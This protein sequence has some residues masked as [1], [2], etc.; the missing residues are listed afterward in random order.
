MGN[1]QKLRL[2]LL[3]VGLVMGVV[4]WTWPTTSTQLQDK[5][6]YEKQQREDEEGGLSKYDRMDLAI[7]QEVEMTKDPA[8]GFVPR[9]R[10]AIA[11][12]QIERSQFSR[13]SIAGTEWKERGSNNVGG[14]T[15]AV[16]FDPNDG[17][18]RRVFAGS[19]SGGLWQC[20]DITAYDPQWEPID[21]LFAN[22][23]VTTIAYDPTNTNTLYFGTGEGFFNG[24]A[25]R[26]DGIWKS[27]DGGSTW[28]QLS[29]TTGN[30]FDYVQKIVVADNGDV[31]AA[32]RSRFCNVGGIYKSTNGG[33]SWSNV[34]IGNGAPCGGSAQYEW[35]SDIEI[36]DNGDLYA[37]MGLGYT[38]GIYKSTD[39]GA[40]WTQLTGGGLP[41]SDYERI[42]LACAPSDSNT[43]LAVMQ[44]ATPSGSND[45][46]GIYLSTDG[47]STWSTL[48]MAIDHASGNEF[49]RG[50]SWYD[51]IAAFDPNDANRI[52]LG[53]VDI[54][55][56]EDQGSTWNTVG[57]WYGDMH[58][59]VHADQHA[60]YFLP[61]SS[62]LLL[63]GNDGG[64]YYSDDAGSSNPTLTPKNR[65]YNTLQ[66][67]A[68]DISPTANEPKLLGGAQDNGSHRIE[69]RGVTY[70][71]EVT[72]GDGAFCHIDQNDAQ[73]WITSY[74]Y[75]QYR[76]SSDSGKDF[77]TVNYSGSIGRFINP[78]DYDDDANIL[79]CAGANSRYVRWNDPHSGSSFDNVSASWSG[80]VS[81]ITVD[82]QN[83]HTVWFGTGSGEVYEVYDAHSGSPTFV[84]R[85]GG[86]SGTPYV[87]GIAIDPSDTNHLLVTFSNYGVSSIYETTDGGSNWTNVDVNGF[88]DMPVRD[89]LISPNSSSEA[90]IATELGV[91]STNNLNGASTVWGA[92]NTGLANVRVDQLNRRSSDN[93]VVAA[94]H[95]R[96]F[97][98]S[99][100]F[101]TTAAAE[102]GS[103]H[104]V[105]YIGQS[106]QFYDDSRSASSYSWNFG[107]GNSSTLQ[108]PAHN[109]N[110][111]GQYTVSLTINGSV[112]ETKTNYI[113]VLPDR[114]IPYEL[115]DGGNFEVNPL[116]FAPE[117]WE[118]TPFERGSSTVSDKNGTNSGSNAWVTGL[119]ESFYQSDSW[120]ELYTPNFD[121][122][123][124]GT[125]TLDF[126][127][128][129][130]VFSNSTFTSD[131]FILQYSTDLGE[132]WTQIGDY[133]GFY[134]FDNTNSSTAF[135]NTI[136][137]MIGNTAGYTLFSLD[138]SS[139][140]GNP[141]VAFRFV[142]RSDYGNEDEGLAI[143]DFTITSTPFLLSIQ[144]M[145]LT[146]RGEGM[147]ALLNWSIET[148]TPVTRLELERSTDGTTF[149]FTAD[150]GPTL[151]GQYIDRDLPGGQYYYRLKAWDENGEISYSNIESVAIGQFNLQLYPNPV[152]AVLHIS[153]PIN[154]TYTI[155]GMSGK[156]Y[157]AGKLLAGQQSILVN[158]L[159]P[160]Q[161]LLRF[162]PPSGETITARFVKY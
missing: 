99:D 107:D 42:E 51:L 150:V 25:V 79:Y 20:Q 77:S 93:L 125:Y 39:D 128:N 111:A 113:T 98:T 24:D 121:F 31:Y 58:Q 45:C 91:W 152:Q 6:V 47:G 80:Q 159:P 123:V 88:P 120:A 133:P 15:R 4:W 2:T 7:A 145:D 50:Q 86:W 141:D 148:T 116:D 105:A 94:T 162:T 89:V 115:T 122:S 59:E 30:G 109:Y 102:F 130:D 57:Q 153:V 19:V 40:T 108:N 61:G 144:S 13:S 36:A 3:A 149:G 1:G 46:L 84:N 101:A 33:S 69:N 62:D 97:Y 129:Y 34:L 21:D 70:S 118:G 54:Y 11:L 127:A 146:A 26:G 103:D 139:L 55:L 160:G 161:F 43:V 38:D 142:F 90:L 16:L 65:G 87:S 106:I 14:R 27:T 8:L 131:G 5:S 110:S 64:V 74:V 156:R 158:T 147:Y 124:S 76:I 100:V 37:S 117:N 151:I 17:T 155:M 92:T 135:R 29:S 134:N 28:T 49:T 23:A 71:V 10:L 143:D 63:L 136:P 75:N 119:T 104:K 112:T 96:G 48:T 83:A 154:G 78:T 18:N 140:S 138:V 85:T 53:G 56:S 44:D 68:A 41:S 126:Y 73:Y 82:D 137:H 22:L 32:T 157:T 60:I 35:A 9:E 132:N 114:A 66:L 52:Y 81:T 12:E 95:G 72:G 67:Y